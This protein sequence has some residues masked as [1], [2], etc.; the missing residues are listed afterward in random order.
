MKTIFLLIAPFILLACST[1][2]A[3]DNSDKEEAARLSHTEPTVTEVG[4]TPVVHGNFSMELV[5]NGQLEAREKAVV[6]F[7][8]Q[9]LITGVNV[10]EG[11]P[12]NAG[13]VLGKVEAFNY[14]KQLNDARTQYEKA[15]IDLEDLL[16]GIWSSELMVYAVKSDVVTFFSGVQGSLVIR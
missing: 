14:R 16:L 4:T 12:V 6:P 13:Q 11:D 3:G 10:Q 7:R 9:E 1:S 5:S 2:N 15:I 8:V